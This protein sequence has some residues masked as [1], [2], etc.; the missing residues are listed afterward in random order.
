[1]YIKIKNESILLKDE[2]LRNLTGMP[3]FK[4]IPYASPN[5]SN[6]LAGEKGK[7]LTQSYEKSPYTHRKPKKQHNNTRWQLWFIKMWEK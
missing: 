7:H 1:M 4:I 6:N 5:E 3:I 2:C